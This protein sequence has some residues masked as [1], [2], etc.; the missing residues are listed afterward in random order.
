MKETTNKYNSLKTVTLT[1]NNLIIINQTSTKGNQKKW[2]KDNFWFK[3]D[4]LGYESLSEY[5]VSS[6]LKYT[7]VNSYV[8]YDIVNINYHNK[9][10]IGCKSKNISNNGQI[11]TLKKLL[12]TELNIDVYDEIKKIN[13]PKE[14]I[15]FVVESIEKAT[16]LNNFGQYLTMLLEVDAFFL[17]EDRHL[18]N[19]SFIYE[20]EK[21]TPTPLYDFG[22]SLFSDTYSD[23]PLEKTYDDCIK[24]IYAKPFTENFDDQC[25]FSEQLYGTQFEYNFS[26]KEVNEIL[27]SVQQYYDKKIILRMHDTLS[28]QLHKYK[29]YE[30][31]NIDFSKLNNQNVQKIKKGKNNQ[32][33][34]NENEK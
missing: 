21:Y 3:A 2:K 1:D 24:E 9:L 23:Y 8:N 13:S 19:I 15:K 20:N 11:V 33:S 4:G 30:N 12:K 27:S 17:N 5:V 10:M 18:N 22:A 28:A 34:N 32:K 26:M 25:D 31:N 7:N 14:K 16:K 6:L 29:V